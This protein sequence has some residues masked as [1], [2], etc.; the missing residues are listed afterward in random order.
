VILRN[1]AAD[2]YRAIK[3]IGDVEVGLHTT[4][5]LYDNV[6]KKRGRDQYLANVSL[7][8]N[9][10]LGGV[11]HVLDRRTGSSPDFIEDGTT[12]IVGWDVTHPTAIDSGENA[13]S[14]AAMVASIDNN[15]AQWPAILAVQTEGRTEMVDDLENMLIS[16]LKVWQ[17]HNGNKLPS[18]ILV[19]RDG[20]SEGEYSRVK[21]DELPKL[22]AACRRMY[23]AAQQPPKSQPSGGSGPKP[24]TTPLQM[25]LPQNKGKKKEEV[26]TRPRITIVIGTKRHHT[27]FYPAPGSEDD[28][29]GNPNAGL[30]VDRGVTEAHNWDFFAQPHAPIKGTAIPVRYFVVHDEIFGH[31]YPTLADRADKLE[32]VTNAL[33][34]VFGRATRSVSLCTPA[35][36][37]DIVCERGRCYLFKSFGAGTEPGDT[38][39]E[40]AKRVTI[41]EKLR[42]SMF[43]I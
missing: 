42:D 16:R 8:I 15:L 18:N 17:K 11:N 39:A 3:C 37:A 7:K 35:K 29:K 28:K 26:L 22:E 36:L 32:E 33:S 19:Y 9:L 27:R 12:M 34:Y 21:A 41:H 13:P 30:V 14:I 4:C 23:A 40:R 5:M 1:N 25:K 43:Y 6:K 10:K 20:V 38:Q 2:I 24:M 31:Y